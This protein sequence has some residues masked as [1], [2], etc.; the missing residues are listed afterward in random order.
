MSDNKML[1]VLLDVWNEYLND[2]YNF[3]T[4]ALVFHIIE[5]FMSAWAIYRLTINKESSDWFTKNFAEVY[6]PLIS[7]FLVWTMT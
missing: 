3:A 7:I 6:G 4:A 2:V 5:A 1:L